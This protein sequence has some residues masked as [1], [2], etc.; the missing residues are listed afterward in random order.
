MGVISGERFAAVG[1]LKRDSSVHPH[2]LR[3]LG[4]CH[5]LPQ[6][7]AAQRESSPKQGDKILLEGQRVDI[8]QT[9][10]IDRILKHQIDRVSSRLR[11]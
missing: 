6:G 1:L 4:M 7:L 9:A 3:T 8:H 11:F 2:A 5:P 10:A